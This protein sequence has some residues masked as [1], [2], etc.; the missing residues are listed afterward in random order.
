MEGRLIIVEEAESTQDLARD[1]AEQG[2]S[3]GLAIMALHQTRGRGRLGRSWISP[4]GKNLAL[5]LILRPDL[6]PA[7]GVLLGLLSSIAAAATIEDRGV[8]AAELRWPNDVLVRG[9]KIAGI[10][11]EARI[12]GPVLEYVIIGIGM[13]VN[14]EISDF[15]AELRSFVTSL[16][17][18]TGTKWGIEEIARSFL[19]HMETLSRRVESEG[20]AFIPPL[21]ENRWA[22]RGRVLRRDGLTGRAEGL[23]SDGALLL[24]TDDG[25]LVRVTSGEPVPLDVHD[26]G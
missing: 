21:W 10:L 24:R 17:I 3:D 18:C 7:Q 8:P 11:P 9:R 25:S 4:P 19:E 13:N 6:A 5:S 20:C 14:T 16:F 15:P 1:M 26:S 2:E 23:D 12:Q 22:H